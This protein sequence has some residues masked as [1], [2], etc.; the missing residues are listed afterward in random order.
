MNIGSREFYDD[1]SKLRDFFEDNNHNAHRDTLK[2]VLLRYEELRSQLGEARNLL[3]RC[4]EKML[5]MHEQ[6][7]KE[8]GG[9]ENLAWITSDVEKF[10]EPPAEGK[11]TKEII[12]DGCGN[13]WSK[14]CPECKKPIMQ[15]VRPGKVQCPECG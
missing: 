1:I 5:I 8:Y 2:R 14:S 7:K 6:T 15:I 4:V 11:G 12:D 3:V 13:Q 9:G 10:L